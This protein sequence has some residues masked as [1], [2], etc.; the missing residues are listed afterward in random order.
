[1]AEALHATPA[2]ASDHQGELE[3]QEDAVGPTVLVAQPTPLLQAVSEEDVPTAAD[4]Q[5]PPDVAADAPAPGQAL[6]PVLV[7][8]I[9]RVS[10]LPNFNILLERFR[11]TCSMV[12]ST[13]CRAEMHFQFLPN[14]P[15][16]V[17]LILFYCFWI[18]QFFHRY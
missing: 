3:P 2:C 11:M 12:A 1:M 4:A 9:Y 8:E 17:L 14:L 15:P 5:P 10:S 7:E 18:Y 16:Y 6:L 13:I